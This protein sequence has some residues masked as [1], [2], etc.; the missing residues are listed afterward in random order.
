[1]IGEQERQGRQSNRNI[2]SRLEA[3]TARARQET[4]DVWSA[5]STIVSNFPLGTVIWLVAFLA[6]TTVLALMH[7]PLQSLPGVVTMLIIPGAAV[8]TALGARPRGTTGRLVLSVC[9]SL[10]VIMSVGGAISLVGPLIGV[11]HPLDSVPQY[12]TWSLLGLFMLLYMS[13]RQ[14]DPVKVIFGDVRVVHAYS[15][16]GGSSLV[17]LSILGVAQLNHSG[18]NRLAVVATTL[19]VLTLLVGVV[20]GWNRESRWPLS[21]M[22]YCASLALLLSASLRG[23]GLYG[24]DVQREFGVASQ[25]LREGRW[26]IPANHDPY[27]SMLSMTVL[28]T[29]LASLV[30]LRLLAFFQLVVPAILALLPVAVFVTIKNV[31]RLITILRPSPRPGVAFAVTAAFVVSSQAYSSQLV[32]ITRQAMALTMLSALVMVF[33]D[34]TMLKR[35]SQVIIGLLTVAIAVTHY[36]TSYLLVGIFIIALPVNR[37]WTKGWLGVPKAK[38]QQHRTVITSRSM[39]NTALVV[40]AVVAAFGWNLGITRNYSLNSASSAV[41]TKGAGFVT[42]TG[43]S[44]IPAPQLEKILESELHRSASWLNPIPGASSVPLVTATSSKLDNASSTPAQAWSWLNFLLQESLWVLSGLALL[45]GLIVLGRRQANHYNPDLVGF[46]AAVLLIGSF[47]R[48]SGTLA[49]LYSPSRAAIVVAIFVAAPVT[50][51]LDDIVSSLNR[52]LKNIALGGIVVAVG[53]MAVWSSGLGTLLFGGVPPGSLSAHGPNARNFT[54]S[55]P[56]IATAVWI[57]DNVAPQYIV[58]SDEYGQLVLLS[59]PAGYHLISEIVP[60]EVDRRSFVYLSTSNLANGHTTVT[61]SDGN[62]YTSYETTLTFFDK[63]FNVV[64]STG[65]TRVYH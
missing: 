1:M 13:V 39:L 61:A 46:T 47:L 44:F 17:V 57:R 14:L 22:L 20:G 30:K 31:P 7:S 36:T 18:S 27:A 21:A 10:L 64:Y 60:S 19:D 63:Y 37:M 16:F 40:L 28:P 53:A 51:L 6:L 25:T 42:S 38:I 35:S 3:I 56:E 15:V 26:V 11:D 55:T 9:L 54:V 41:S 34:R 43:S 58:Q 29:V 49:A 23:G 62:L 2:V 8:L 59:Q 24:W 45:Y 65:A 48:F 12:L 33:Y 52:R 5:R 4:V 50:M 32:S